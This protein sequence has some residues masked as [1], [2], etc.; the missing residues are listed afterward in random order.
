MNLL[1]TIKILFGDFIAEVGR[2][3]IF[4]PI[5]ENESLHEISNDN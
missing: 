3:E 2:A 5:A 4:K 1:N